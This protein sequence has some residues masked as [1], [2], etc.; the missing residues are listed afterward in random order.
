MENLNYN[1]DKTIDI[2]KELSFPD[3][4]AEEKLPISYKITIVIS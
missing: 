2:I 4:E 3:S 1:S